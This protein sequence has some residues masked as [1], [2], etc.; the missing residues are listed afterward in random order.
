MD[1]PSIPKPVP[2]CMIYH[3]TD[4]FKGEDAP[5]EHCGILYGK[6]SGRRTKHAKLEELGGILGVI[7]ICDKNNFGGFVL[8]EN[9]RGQRGVTKVY[10]RNKTLDELLLSGNHKKVSGAH[11]Y[12]RIF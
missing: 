7:K 11:L 12:V 8:Q 4:A 5:Y 9:W 10:F 1:A 3:N 2:N 6:A